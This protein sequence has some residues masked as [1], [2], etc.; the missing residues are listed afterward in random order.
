MT[1]KD[2]EYFENSTKCWICDNDY[3]DGDVEVKDH[4]HI[5]GKHGSSAHRDCNINGKL[6]HKISVKFHNLKNYDS[7]LIMLELSRFNLQTNVIPNGLESIWAL[8]SITSLVLLVA[9]N[10]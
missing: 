2:N 3:I 10:F 1:K 4:C 8:V 9:S 6:S 7:H 5:T